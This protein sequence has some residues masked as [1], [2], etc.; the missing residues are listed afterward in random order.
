MQPNDG[1][2]VL[3]QLMQANLNRDLNSDTLPTEPREKI[4]QSQHNKCLTQRY[5]FNN[6]F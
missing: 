5:K 4:Q 1:N 2:T 3:S 6:L